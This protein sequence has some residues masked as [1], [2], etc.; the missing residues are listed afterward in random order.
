M[1][2]SRRNLIRI[3]REEAASQES[4]SQS[5]S[6]RKVNESKGRVQLSLS[7]MRE[8]IREEVERAEKLQENDADEHIQAVNAVI[9]RLNQQAPASDASLPSQFRTDMRTLDAATDRLSGPNVSGDT[10]FQSSSDQM[11]D[12]D[13]KAHL[14]SQA[15]SL[16]TDLRRMPDES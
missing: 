13:A 12:A 4:K 11:A 2:V 10:T 7:R 14:I 8:I 1:K 16:V 5:R 6:T 3:I 9:N 15:R